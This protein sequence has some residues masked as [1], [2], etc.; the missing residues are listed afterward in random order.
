MSNQIILPIA[1]KFSVAD[2]IGEGNFKVVAT[3]DTRPEAA[4]F[5]RRP[6]IKEALLGITG[7][8]QEIANAL[9]EH[10]ETVEVAFESGT[11]RRVT[12]AEHG[13]LQKAL[14]A[15]AARVEA[16]DKELAFLAEVAGDIRSSF[17]YETVKRLSDE[18]KAF[19]ANNT[20]RTIPGVDEEVAKFLVSNREALK[21][22]FNAGVP[23]REVSEKA[24]SGLAAYQAE[25][26]QKKEARRKELADERADILKENPEFVF[27]RNHFVDKAEFEAYNSK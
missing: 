25:Q 12:K 20:L 11:I 17:K 16:G 19:A 21:E 27:Q 9:V 5:I 24:M 8:T 6:L 2:T 1:G 4:D 13:K 26:A 18:E 14:E 3:F 23:K 10:Q 7:M 15:V 22:A